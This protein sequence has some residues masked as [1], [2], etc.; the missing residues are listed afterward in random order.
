[1]LSNCKLSFVDQ[2]LRRKTMRP[3]HPSPQVDPHGHI[4]RRPL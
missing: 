1:M 2:S 3:S 4:T